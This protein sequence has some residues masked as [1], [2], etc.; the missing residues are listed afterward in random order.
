MTSTKP[1]K[2]PPAQRHKHFPRADLEQIAAILI[3]AETTTASEVVNKWNISHTTLSRYRKRLQ[4]DMHLLGLVQEKLEC[5]QVT[6]RPPEFPTALD[7]VNAA[8]QWLRDSIPKL[9][10]SPENVHA[11]VGAAKILRQQDMAERAMTE[12]INALKQQQ[13]ENSD[14]AAAQNGRSVPGQADAVPGSS[15]TN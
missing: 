2:R 6:L 3:D 14:T 5:L 13:L 10:P 15:V 8:Y 4:T 11:V 1:P 7:V 9:H 12:Y